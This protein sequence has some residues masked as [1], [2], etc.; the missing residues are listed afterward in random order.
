MRR[1]RKCGN[2]QL[3]VK[4]YLLVSLPSFFH[5]HRFRTP[6]IKSL[7]QSLIF[8]TS[9]GFTHMSESDHVCCLTTVAFVLALVCFSPVLAFV[10][11]IYYLDELLYQ[12]G[13]ASAKDPHEV[14]QPNASRSCSNNLCFLLL[15]LASWVG[16]VRHLWHSGLAGR[17]HGSADARGRLARKDLWQGCGG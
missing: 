17:N 6:D 3:T 11:C 9:H 1:R 4:Y 12:I 14:Y 15:F 13:A 16:P 2:K 10:S 8:S 5:P 7:F